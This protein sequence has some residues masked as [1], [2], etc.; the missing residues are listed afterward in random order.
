MTARSRFQAVLFDLDGTLLD[1]L[2][3]LADASNA[4]LRSLG[5]PE[6]P[7]QSYKLFVGDGVESLVRRALP[8][9]RCEPATIAQCVARMRQEYSRHWG[10]KTHPYPGI[11]ELLDALLA[12]GIHRA[13]LS[14]KPDDFTRL[15]VSRFLPWGNFTAVVGQQSGLAKKPD[16]A[17]ARKIAAQ[18]GLAPAEI[19]YLGDTNTDMQTAVAAGMFPVGATWGFRTPEELRASGAQVLVDNP[20]EVLELLG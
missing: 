13:V 18:F 14:N 6:H 12:R 11:V 4:A 15:C 9:E 3:D 20:L 2:A 17:G 8:A 10:D 16:P 19:L 7:Y 5:C 1:T